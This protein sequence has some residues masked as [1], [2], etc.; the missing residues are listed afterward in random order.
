MA[1][2]VGVEAL[3]YMGFEGPSPQIDFQGILVGVKPREERLDAQVM[4][5]ISSNTLL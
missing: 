4:L 1:P 3:N 5:L 2:N